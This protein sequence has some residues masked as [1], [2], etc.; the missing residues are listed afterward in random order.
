MEQHGSIAG[1]KYYDANQNGVND[2]QEP[3]L[4]GWIIYIDSNNNGVRDI[5]TSPTVYTATDLPKQILD[6]PVAST[7]SQITVGSVGT[8]FNVEVTLDITHSFV[9]DLNAYLVSPSGK[10]VLL[11]DG[12]GG[13]FN[14]F[15]NLTFSDS[16]ARNISTIGFSDWNGSYTGTWQPMGLLSD[17]S[18]DD[19]GGIWTLVV[20]DSDFA[21]QGILNSW[22]LKIT[23]GELF[24]VTDENGDYSFDN[25]VAGSYVVREEPKPGFVQIPPTT[26]D[27]PAATWNNSQWNVNVIAIDD[28]NDPIPDSHRNVQDVDFGN[29]GPAGS[30][31][32]YVYKDVNANS[33]KGPGEPGLPNWTVYIDSDGSGTLDLD[34]VDDTVFTDSAQAINNFFPVSS[35]LYFG[36]VGRVTNVT[37]T[38]DITH[39]YDNDLTA[40][41]VSPSGTHVKLFSHIGG[42]GD[43]FDFTTFD[44]GAATSITSGT[45]PFGDV[46]GQRRR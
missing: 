3:G 14:N 34:A 22:S 37:V 32:G 44:D 31:E 36:S 9:G 24:R 21:D 23:S 8:I 18:G 42:S 33:A 17:F 16:A 46:S 39:T 7:S 43:D 15:Q 28:F 29:F 11:F 10:S 40:Y 38:L 4:P 12:V 1:Q 20:Q 5:S 27:I 13:Q 6:P 25:L 41:L 35:K 2:D 26:T 30:L 19:A 45:A